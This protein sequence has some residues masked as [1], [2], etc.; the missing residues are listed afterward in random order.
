MQNIYKQIVQEMMA[1]G[2][3][4]DEDQALI[5]F[6]ASLIAL[7]DRLSTNEAFHLGT[8]LPEPLREEYF[9]GWDSLRK[10]T[11]SV[12]KSE[13]L[14]EVAFHLDN[15]EDISLDDLVPVALASI[16]RLVKSEDAEQVKH[17][18]PGSMQDIFDDRQAI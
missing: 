5:I 11:N 15:H 10:P 13:F 7:R 6:K 1:S 16:L 18:I 3:F 8:R 9:F 2:L 4:H 12:N 17:A 14:A